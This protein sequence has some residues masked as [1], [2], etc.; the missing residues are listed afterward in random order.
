[1]K[2]EE[3]EEEFDD[4]TVWSKRLS[5]KSSISCFLPRQDWQKAELKRQKQKW[6]KSVKRRRSLILIKSVEYVFWSAFLLISILFY[7]C[8]ITFCFQ[9]YFVIKDGKNK[10]DR[11][12]KQINEAKETKLI[13]RLKQICITFC[14]RE[15]VAWAFLCVKSFFD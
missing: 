8:Y 6:S 2:K 13:S 3:K 14:G 5:V 12:S 1:M 11:K 10:F 4:Q 7:F 15:D 9:T